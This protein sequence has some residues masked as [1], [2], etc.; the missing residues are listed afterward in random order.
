M[1]TIPTSISLVS[2]SGPIYDQQQQG[3]C[4]ANAYCADIMLQANEYHQSLPKLSAQFVYNDTR[5]LMN[6]FPNDSGSV[7]SYAQKA[8]TTDGVANESSFTYGGG[9]ECVAPS[10]AVYDEAATQKV[11]SFTALNIYQ[12]YGN[13]ANTIKQYLLQGKGVLCTTQELTLA[14]GTYIQGGHEF[15]IVGADDNTG[16]YT[17]QNSWGAG[18]G[19]NGY[20]QIKYTE[21]AVGWGHPTNEL[22]G[23]DV[24]NGFKGVDVTWTIERT[25][26][27]QLYASVLN[28]SG[29]NFGITAWAD[30]VKNG[31]SLSSL[32]N[33]F[34]NSN[35][36][37]KLYKAMDDGQYINQLFHNILNRDVDKPGLDFFKSQLASGMSRGD[38]AYG[39][40]HCIDTYTGT[41][42]S[43]KASHDFLENRTTVSMNYGITYQVNGDHYDAAVNS[44]QNVTDDA[45][46]I[47]I[48]LVGI[49]HAVYNV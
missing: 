41:D 20:G 15:I 43:T 47:H 5:M 28:R 25:R 44:L 32:S 30:V 36:G 13:I 21:F 23:L 10:Q 33:I 24:I 9:N 45:D 29:E 49:Q 35:E 2:F 27:A 38:L 14:D 8:V 19:N 48:A 7:V 16:M 34:Y 12:S 1:S 26:V 22:L 6:T 17:I 18:W 4:V 37:Q 3:S 40:M 42:A 46:S 39:I 31:M 11:L